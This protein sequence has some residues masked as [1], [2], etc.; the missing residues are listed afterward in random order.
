M[1]VGA[2]CLDFAVGVIAQVLKLL[3]EKVNENDERTASC[4]VGSTS[5]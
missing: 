5:L 3:K 4:G 2:A 1:G